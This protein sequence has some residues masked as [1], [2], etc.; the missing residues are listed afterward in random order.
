MER[1]EDTYTT[2][3]EWQHLYTPKPSIVKFLGSR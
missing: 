2:I 3:H 1:K